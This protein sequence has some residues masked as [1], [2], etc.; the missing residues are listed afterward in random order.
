MIHF[1]RNHFSFYCF[2]LFLNEISNIES[3]FFS[4]SILFY[5]QLIVQVNT[6][7]RN[8]VLID[9]FISFMNTT[10]NLSMVVIQF[11]I[12]LFL[13][14]SS[15]DRVSTQSCLAPFLFSRLSNS[16]DI[17]DIPDCSKVRRVLS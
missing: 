10:L 1:N 5:L 9:F 8:S 2:F 16:L 11:L 3:L 13:G 7:I 4:I 12:V 17:F 14:I 6:G 15:I